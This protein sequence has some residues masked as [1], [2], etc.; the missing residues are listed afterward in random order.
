MHD[1][2]IR[3]GSVVDGKGGPAV[4]ADIAVDDGQI[5]DVGKVTAPARQTLDA[6]G[7]IVT[8]GWV[9]IHTHYDGQATWDPLLA[10]SFLHGVTT[11]VMGNCGVGFAPVR[12]GR[13]AW[14]TGLMEGVEDIPGAALTAGIRWEW[15]SFPEY[16]DALDAMPRAIDVGAQLAH[17]ALRA[18][19]MGDRGAR[20]EPATPDDVAQMAALAGEAMEAGAM[21]FSTNRTTVHIAIDGEQVPG[22]FAE[23]DELL[24]ICRA[25]ARSGS[26][27]VEVVPSGVVGENVAAPER[28]IALLHHLSVETGCR[29]TFLLGQHNAAPDQWRN[30]LRAADEA[31]A[32]GAHLVPQ[33]FGRPTG[34]LFSF[35]TI[36]PFWR[37][38]S[39]QP[40]LDMEHERRLAILRDPDF[41]KRLL[42]EEDA[43]ADAR[44]DILRDPWAQTYDLGDPPQY[45]PDPATSIAER[46]RRENRSPREVAY[47][48]MLED[49]GTRFLVY[50][51]LGYADG[52]LSPVYT[53]LSHPNSVIGGSDA[54]A[55]CRYICDG[56]VPTYMLTHWAR[57]RTRGPRLPLEF[58]VRK[59]TSDT[60]RLYGL[61]DRGV[62]APGRKADINLIDLKALDVG[63]PHLVYDLPAGE[64]RL[65]QSASG[66]EAVLVA[67]E[68]VQRRGEDT[69]ARPGR[70]VRGPSRKPK[71]E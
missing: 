59:Q 22:T 30:T 9:D 21:G 51:F 66:Y 3:G 47:D 7:L 18:Y 14:L 71:T 57:D 27:V 46:A 5:T 45:E 4:T 6:D 24:P 11:V 67:G 16:L 10:P 55:H 29:V 60:A 28:E 41:R 69:G 62:L 12:P 1:L 25:V 53:M 20:N 26:G 19:V 50:C 2:V 44:Q 13:E 35:R 23:E 32:A 40:L 54:G 31:N 42:A 56:S 64:R 34:F 39:F 38:P 36:H 49:G 52:D 8:P 17:G 48:L 33:V 15:E 43:V 63:A 58:V 70:L 68:V 37:F 65:M 61:H